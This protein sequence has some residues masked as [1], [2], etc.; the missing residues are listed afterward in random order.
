MR[1]E[2]NCLY[3]EGAVTMETVPALV[4]EASARCGE[5]VD[6]VDFG[7]VTEIDSAAIALALE[8]RRRSGRELRFANLPT[9]AANL[10]RL[11]SLADDF[12]LDR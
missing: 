8:L 5:D 2:G 4:D 1:C 9:S 6:T 12:G 7:A 10:A 11:Y 3:L